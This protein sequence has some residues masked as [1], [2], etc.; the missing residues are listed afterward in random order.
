M[1]FD[2]INA[3]G[4]VKKNPG[5]W[6]PFIWIRSRRPSPPPTPS[7]KG[8][9]SRS[10]LTR[11]CFYFRRHFQPEIT[12][13]PPFLW[14]SSSQYHSLMGLSTSPWQVKWYLSYI[15]SSQEKES[16]EHTASLHAS[17]HS[18]SSSVISSSHPSSAHTW[19]SIIS[20]TAWVAFHFQW[21]RPPSACV[22]KFKK[23]KS[24]IKI[25]YG[26]DLPSGGRDARCQWWREVKGASGWWAAR[27]LKGWWCQFLVEKWEKGFRRGGCRFFDVFEMCW[28]G[29]MRIPIYFACK[30]ESD[31]YFAF[32]TVASTWASKLQGKLINSRSKKRVSAN[33][34]LSSSFPSTSL[35]LP[36]Y[37]NK[38][39]RLGQCKW[40]MKISNSFT[41]W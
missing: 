5:T 32:R 35:T 34:P 26:L 15:S 40:P 23:Y 30:A 29:D 31:V 25:R 11:T 28:T 33:I 13:P 14:H 1:R 18:K 7:K 36:W 3:K 22:S 17:Q 39:Q 16:V 4:C 27:S 38:N 8:N 12:L 19:L 10:F 6:G 24:W 9:K 21:G 2:G 41:F 20:T 37:N